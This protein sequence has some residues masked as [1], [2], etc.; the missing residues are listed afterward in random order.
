MPPIYTTR[1]MNNR[2][3]LDVWS[4]ELDSFISVCLEEFE[5]SRLAELADDVREDDGV[6]S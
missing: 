4:R 5:A 1:P 6:V 2:V 3:T